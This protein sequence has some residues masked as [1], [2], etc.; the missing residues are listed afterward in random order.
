M[1]TLTNDVG[2]LMGN[3]QCHAMHLNLITVLNHMVH[4]YLFCPFF[5]ETF[6]DLRINPNRHTYSVSL[7]WQRY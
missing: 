6:L 1:F 3:Q 2:T 5:L 4:V 7:G